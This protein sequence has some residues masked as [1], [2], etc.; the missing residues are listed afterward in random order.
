MGF[1]GGLIIGLVFGSISGIILM[2]I[3]VASKEDS[4]G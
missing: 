4:D 3:I 2:A 1:W